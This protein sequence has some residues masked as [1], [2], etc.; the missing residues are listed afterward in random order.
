MYCPKCLKPLSPTEVTYCCHLLLSL[1]IVKYHSKKIIAELFPP[2]EI[3]TLKGNTN[4][5]C[6][7]SL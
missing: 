1:T 7:I 6:E 4:I 5:Y 3:Q 2:S